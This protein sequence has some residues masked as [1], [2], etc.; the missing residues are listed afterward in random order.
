MSSSWWNW[1]RIV[2]SV[3]LAITGLIYLWKPQGT[4][5][6][7][8]S[9]I[10]GEL[11]LIYVAGVLWITLG[12]MIA[13]NVKTKFATYGVITLLSCYQM[14]VHIPA[15]Y[16]G[17]HLNVVWFELLRDL[18]LMGGAFFIMAV[19]AHAQQEQEDG[20]DF[21]HAESNSTIF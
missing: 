11:G 18:S 13:F 21:Y 8:T 15:V 6:S 12:L 19:E 7:L 5:E 9:F 16:T 14:M 10:P 3:P 2:Y 17:E 4:V 20:G 1:G